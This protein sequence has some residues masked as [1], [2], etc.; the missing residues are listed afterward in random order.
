MDLSNVDHRYGQGNYVSAK[1]GGRVWESD[2]GKASVDVRA[3]YGQH[4]GGPYGKTPARYG[5]GV[6]F[7]FGGK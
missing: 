4:F 1:A 5:A 3:N 2:N 7:G 6:R